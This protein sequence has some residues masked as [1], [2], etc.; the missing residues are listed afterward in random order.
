[1][2]RF[3][4]MC[5][6]NLSLYAIFQL[7]LGAE[8]SAYSSW[9]QILSQCRLLL[10]RQGIAQASQAELCRGQARPQNHKR[11]PQYQA[12]Q[13]GTFEKISCQLQAVQKAAQAS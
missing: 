11:L 13:A 7:N 2:A 10:A 8:R 5:R 1:M 12:T 3:C 4:F 6:R 9:Q